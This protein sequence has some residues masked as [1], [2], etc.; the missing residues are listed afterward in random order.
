[1]SMGEV[2][3]FHPTSASHYLDNYTPTQGRCD[4]SDQSGSSRFQ[5]LFESALRDYE[6]QTGITL[7]N[8]PLAEQLQNCQS[9]ESVTTLLQGQARDFS[10]FKGSDK[11]MKSL[12]SAVSVIA[13]LGQ[14]ISMV[15]PWPLIRYSRSLTSIQKSFPPADTVYTGLGIL[16]SVCAIFVSTCV[17]CNIQVS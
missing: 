2:A 3:L 4:M 16:L 13:A 14:D 15:C 17:S 10:K 9:V 5:A 1:M 11:I 6:K 12:K 7:A 8:H